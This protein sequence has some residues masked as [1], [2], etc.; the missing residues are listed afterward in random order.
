MQADL[1]ILHGMPA[2]FVGDRKT[3]G[4]VVMLALLEALWLQSYLINAVLLIKPDDSD[5][6]GIGGEGG[7][8]I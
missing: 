2:V 4:I 3:G 5:S 8:G 7:G 1:F 6:D